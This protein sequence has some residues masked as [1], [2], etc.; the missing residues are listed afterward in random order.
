MEFTERTGILR[1]GIE[2]MPGTGAQHFELPVF[3][4]TLIIQPQGR[5]S[6]I[7]VIGDDGLPR[8]W[9]AS[10]INDLSLTGNGGK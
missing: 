9:Y 7:S 4:G 2:A 1:L 10:Q 5:G 8:T 3:T 6:R